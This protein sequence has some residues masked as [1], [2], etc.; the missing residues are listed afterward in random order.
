MHF[1]LKRIRDNAEVTFRPFLPPARQMESEELYAKS[2]D[3]AALPLE[4]DQRA[5]QNGRA[6]SMAKPDTF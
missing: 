5:V 4:T 3:N 6:Y 2:R 1:P